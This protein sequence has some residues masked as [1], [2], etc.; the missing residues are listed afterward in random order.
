[1]VFSVYSG[2]HN[3]WLMIAFLPILQE[4]TASVRS[5]IAELRASNG[6]YKVCG[7]GHLLARFGRED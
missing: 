3:G 5:D 7:M 4:D 1:M 2:E 6:N